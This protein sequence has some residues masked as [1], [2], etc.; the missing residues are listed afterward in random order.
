MRQYEEHWVFLTIS[1]IMFVHVASYTRFENNCVNIIWKTMYL[2]VPVDSCPYS[3][4][5]FRDRDCM[6]VVLTI[7]YAIS[8]YHH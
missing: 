1:N 8:I 2:P 5:G 7:T 6:V 3:L 4:R